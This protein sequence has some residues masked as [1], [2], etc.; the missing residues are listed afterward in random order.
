MNKAIYEEPIAEIIILEQED[1]LSDS[2]VL[3]D[4]WDE[5]CT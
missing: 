3:E 5:L 1:I 2:N 4:E